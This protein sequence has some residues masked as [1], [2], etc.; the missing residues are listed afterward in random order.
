MLSVSSEL[1]TIY[2]ANLGCVDNRDSMQ[3]RFFYTK[4]ILGMAS[5]LMLSE[6]DDF[7]FQSAQPW[8]S[9]LPNSTSQESNFLGQ[10]FPRTSFCSNTI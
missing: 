5:P 6:L 2:Q 7:V 1:E 8:V 4:E 10:S 9:P 3:F